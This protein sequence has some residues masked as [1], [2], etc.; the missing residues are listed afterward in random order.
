M[1][2]SR[3]S[4]AST[5][6]HQQCQLALTDVCSRSNNDVCRCVEL[7]ST[8]AHTSIK[9][10][11]AS[12]TRATSVATSSMQPALRTRQQ[13]FDACILHANRVLG[14]E[15]AR[16]AYGSIRGTPTSSNATPNSTLRPRRP[17]RV[18]RGV[19]LRPSEL[20]T[21]YVC[22]QGADFYSRRHTPRRHTPQPPA[23]EHTE[24]HAPSN[25]QTARA[26]P[27]EPLARVH[28]RLA[29][30]SPEGTD[31]RSCPAGTKYGTLG[32]TRIATCVR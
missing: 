19:D 27:L 6:P 32:R 22:G 20:T 13:Q 7:V 24:E 4:A 11:Y 26:Y 12:S 3:N 18:A 25:S 8:T 30:R 31:L 1:R 15:R 23:L 9:A 10:F 28:L 5:R 14:T 21:D 16:R 2:Q 29:K 17:V